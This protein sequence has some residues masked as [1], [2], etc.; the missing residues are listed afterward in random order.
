M[1]MCYLLEIGLFL[2]VFTLFW[3]SATDSGIS[4]SF[5]DVAPSYSSEIN[6]V[7][8]VINCMAGVVAPLVC[9]TLVGRFG[10]ASGWRVVF[11]LTA[12]LSVTATGLWAAF[13]RSEIVPVLNSRVK[14][15]RASKYR[16]GGIGAMLVCR[17]SKNAE[18]N[19]KTQEQA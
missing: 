6:T 18:R 3:F 11:F 13:F 9:S 2:L 7:A 5:L 16:L 19:S 4:S 1:F 8:N 14:D 15:A 17:K 10:G 12:A